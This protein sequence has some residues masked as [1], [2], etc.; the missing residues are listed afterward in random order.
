MGGRELAG[1]SFFLLPQALDLIC[2]HAHRPLPVPAI[3]AQQLRRWQNCRGGATS[4]P[5]PPGM[6]THTPTIK[7]R[8]AGRDRTGVVVAPR[9]RGPAHADARSGADCG[10]DRQA[11]I[12]TIAQLAAIARAWIGFRYRWGIYLFCKTLAC[13]GTCTKEAGPPQPAE[14]ALTECCENGPLRRAHA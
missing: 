5:P 8:S 12:G 2:T 9:H 4:G 6:L 11:R 1:I 7:C 3:A 14:F 13:T 10:G